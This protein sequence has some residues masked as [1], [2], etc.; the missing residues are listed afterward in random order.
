VDGRLRPGHARRSGDCNLT[1]TAADEASFDGLA[2]DPG[3]VRYTYVFNGQF[4]YLDH[5]MANE[6]LLGA[7][8]GTDAWLINPDEASLIDYELTFEQPAQQA[9]FAPDP[10]ARRITTRYWSASTCVPST[11][12]PPSR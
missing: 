8:T 4:G 9:L 6:R 5:A 11:R 7:V 1:R 3:R 12:H 10:S 2:G